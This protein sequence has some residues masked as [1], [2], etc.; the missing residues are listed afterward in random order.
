MES[1][2]EKSLDQVIK[3]LTQPVI[4]I[5]VGMQ[6]LCN[7]SEENNTTGLGIIDINVKK[8]IAEERN[9]KVPQMGWNNIYNLSSSLFE[10]VKENSFFY[11][12]AS[13]Y[14]ELGKDTIA[15]TDYIFHYST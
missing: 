3:H 1:L 15:S 11:Y 7:H 13:Y 10:G 4:G 5:C 14:A 2:K 8:F 12:V 6:L 9:Y